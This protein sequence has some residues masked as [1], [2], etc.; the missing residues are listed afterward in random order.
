MNFPSV[1]NPLMKTKPIR[2]LLATA[3]LGVLASL[4]YAGPGPQYWQTLRKPE[5]FKQ[6]KAGDKIA[7]VCNQCQTVSEVTVDSPAHAME[8]CKEGAEVTCPQCKKKVKVVT[9]GPPKNP[10]I[11]RQVSYVNEKGEPCLF[12]AKVPEKK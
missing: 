8:H 5:E 1:A 2:S 10:S 12:V 7:Y 6:L 3:V 11:E 4:A 9:K